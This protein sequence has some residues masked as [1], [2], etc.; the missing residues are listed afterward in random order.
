MY[1]SLCQE[2]YLNSQDAAFFERNHTGG[3]MR[4]DLGAKPIK[5]YQHFVMFLQAGEK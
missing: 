5:I 3:N 1:Y 4:E 2:E